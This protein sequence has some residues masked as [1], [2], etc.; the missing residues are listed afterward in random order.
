MSHANYSLTIR[1][2]I[3]ARVGMLGQ[4]M[5]AIGEAGAQV[6]GVDIV[7]STKDAVTRDIT[8]Y[9]ADDAH[10]G[11]IRAAVEGVEGVRVESVNDRV[12]LSHLGGK[13]GM[14][15]RV[16]VATRDDLSMA[17]TPGVARVCMAI[18]HD[19]DQAW[20]YTIK[21]NSVMVVSD[22]SSVV[23]QGDLGPE[24]SLPALE[25]K[26]AFMHKLAGIDA[27]PL[28]VDLRDPA[29]IA[30]AVA[31]VS[32]VFA[33]IH[34]S[35]IAAPR[36]FEVQELLDERLDIPVFHEDQQGTAAAVLAALTN[37]LA[38]AGT[39]LSD[40][41]VVVAGLGPG[42]QAVVRLLADASVGDVVACDSSGAVHRDR[43]DAGG[44]LAWIAENTNSRGLRGSVAEVL[45]GADA[46]VGLSA[47]GLLSA[48]DVRR[49][50]P[51]PVVLALAMPDPEILP[52]EAAGVARVYA[53]G[54]PDV[55]NQINSGLASPGIWRG[56]LDCR[57]TE[58]NQAMTLAAA[59]AIAETA[60]QE[61]GPSQFNV[62]P[63]IFN[64]RLVPNVA[65]AVR[66]AAEATGV[67]RLTGSAAGV[68]K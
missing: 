12:F 56:A 41:T 40:A 47:P 15:N 19:F 46:F 7:R 49:M 66:A 43:D 45:A 55:P 30:E 29:E 50:A 61:T 64:D 34:L 65:A 24:A 33:G 39:N 13:V 68:A 9:A 63:S 21:G 4:V 14:Q 60:A 36:C 53:T 44:D 48:D 17:Y 25:A 28:P 62:V 5:G 26:C 37:G 27:F 51:D 2:V 57:A 10:S 11:A 38:L 16:P 31:L 52:E 32:S 58:I 42:G 20:E 18:N 35:D 59:T 3:P 8:V 6:G 54:R 1:A 22:G 23:G 67:A